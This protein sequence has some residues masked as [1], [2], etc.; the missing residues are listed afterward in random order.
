M[1]VNYSL[2]LLGEFYDNHLIRFVRYLK[3]ENPQVQI[4]FFTPSIAGRIIPTDYLD[5][6]RTCE[7]VDFSKYFRFVPGLNEMEEVHNWHKYF[8]V[9]SKSL[10][11]DVVNIHYPRSVYSSVLPEISRI[12]DNLVLT[13]WGSDVLRISKK[14]RKKLQQVYDAADYITGRG[15]RFCDD[16]MRIFN[17][18]QQ[19]FAYKGIGSEAIDYIVDNKSKVDVRTAKQY[20]GIEDSYVITCGYNASRAQQHI[21]ILDSIG[22]IKNKLPQNLVLLFPVTY[23]K[24]PD[25]IAL[26]K[27]TVKELGI[28]SIFCED[29]LELESLF[30]LRQ[31]TDMFIHV[32]TT[33]A[34]SAS[35]KEYVL[36][37]KNC[38]NG[39]WLK[40]PD[41]ESNDYKPY[42]TV[43]NLNELAMAILNA[44]QKGTPEIKDSVTDYIKS[45]GCKPTA[46]EWNDFFMS[47]SK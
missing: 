13:P 42:H 28:Y 46:K 5:C 23:P 33:D 36:L 37:G 16:F 14:Q 1:K 12:A 34:N 2:L 19:K 40:Y 45:L 7:V 25:Y 24:N 38:I 39:G 8:R 6:F 47:I 15:G 3:K 35:L 31:A 22:K 29:Y 11:Y 10:H 27:S 9:F 41:V 20:F 26:L 30:Y 17:V 21:Q 43:K 18:P 32:Q 4:D 44:Y